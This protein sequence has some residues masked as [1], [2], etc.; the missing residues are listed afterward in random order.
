M[1]G[2]VETFEPSESG[3]R[4]TPGRLIEILQPPTLTTSSFLKCGCTLFVPFTWKSLC[5]NRKA[6]LQAEGKSHWGPSE[7]PHPPGTV[8]CPGLS[9]SCGPGAHRIRL[10]W[11][12]DGV[13]ESSPI[14][15]LRA[16]HGAWIPWEMAPS[17]AR[18]PTPA[19]FTVCKFSKK[20]RVE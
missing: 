9:G 19:S 3:K 13:A 14:S 7:C 5:K 15:S 17:G 2:S 4:C 18:A 12:E 11:E 20:G 1:L 8:S 16:M 10:T 6:A